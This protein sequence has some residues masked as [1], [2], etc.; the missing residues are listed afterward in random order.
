MK[1]T[2]RNHPSQRRHPIKK[3]EP[4]LDDDGQPVPLFPELR[5][6]YLDDVMCGYCDCLGGPVTLTCHLPVD[7]L[8][9]IGARVEEEF[10]VK[11]T[12]VNMP[13]VAPDNPLGETDDE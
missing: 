6:I 4:L 3:D 13:P 5:A 8:Q 10:S 1:I 9:A 7:V 12:S 2:F 11:P